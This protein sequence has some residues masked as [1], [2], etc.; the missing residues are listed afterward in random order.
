MSQLLTVQDNDRSLGRG[1]DVFHEALEIEAHGG[2][3][4]I[5]VPFPLDPSIPKD[6][7]CMH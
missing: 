7:L 4:K 1:S 5:P 3:V 2:G 6:V